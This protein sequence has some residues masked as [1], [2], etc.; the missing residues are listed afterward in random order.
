M[1]SIECMIRTLEKMGRDSIPIIIYYAEDMSDI[2]DN[3][4]SVDV[5]CDHVNN[6][7]GSMAWT[8]TVISKEEDEAY[9][10]EFDDHLPLAEYEIVVDEPFSDNVLCRAI[11]CWLSDNGLGRYDFN[12]IMV[13]LEDAAPYS[14]YIK[15][16]MERD[17]EEE[18]A[19]AI[20]LD[21]INDYVDS[22]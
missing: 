7:C 15:N 11:Q 20:P 21:D 8:W 4:W 17:I 2:K 5:M 19:N 16:L 3:M 13:K 6:S 12:I 22:D 9:R 14:G 18:L 1:D 10:E